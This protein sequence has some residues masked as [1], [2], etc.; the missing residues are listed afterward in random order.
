VLKASAKRVL[1]RWMYTQ[2]ANGIELDVLTQLLAADRE[3]AVQEEVERERAEDLL[4]RGTLAREDER[5]AAAAVAVVM[6]A[7]RAA[8]EIQDLWDSV[9]AQLDR[10]VDEFIQDEVAAGGGDEELKEESVGGKLSRY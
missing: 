6:P 8:Q 1:W 7:A 9:K 3:E 4:R 10:S 2:L 5:L